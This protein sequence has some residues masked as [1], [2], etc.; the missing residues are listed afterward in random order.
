MLDEHTRES[1]ICGR[2]TLTGRVDDATL[3]AWYEAANLFVHPTQ[4][5]S[6]SLET[7]EAMAHG[8]AVLAKLAGGL[9]DKVRPGET[10]WLVAAEFSWTVAIDRCLAACRELLAPLR[11]S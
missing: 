1:G 8:R 6:S 5:E 2:V 9:P 4:Y 7:L 3:H 10:G 11:T